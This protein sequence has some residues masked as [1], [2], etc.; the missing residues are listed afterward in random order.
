M[1]ISKKQAFKNLVAVA[2][3][4]NNY[5]LETAEIIKASIIK[6]AEEL[7]IPIEKPQVTEETTEE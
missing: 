7:E 1:E 2:Y 5:T 3:Q 6:L 4:N